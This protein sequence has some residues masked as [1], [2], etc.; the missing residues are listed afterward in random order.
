MHVKR[1]PIVLMSDESGTLEDRT[2]PPRSL[3]DR[4][5][6]GSEMLSPAPREGVELESTHSLTWFWNIV[7]LV[8]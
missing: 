3:N 2:L 4:M 6:D 7:K 8:H 1:L 5:E